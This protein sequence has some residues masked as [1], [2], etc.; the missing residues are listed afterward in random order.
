MNTRSIGAV[1]IGLA[2]LALQSQFTGAEENAQPAGDSV[3]AQEPAAG[4]MQD[5]VAPE[6]KSDA[7]ETSGVTGTEAAGVTEA[8]VV[9]AQPTGG[10]APAA[11]TDR[12]QTRESDALAAVDTDPAATDELAETERRYRDAVEAI[13]AGGGAYDP[14]LSQQLLGLGLSYQQAGRHLEA[15]E[16]LSRAAHITRVNEGLFSASGIPIIEQLIESHAALGE[17]EE[18]GNRYHQMF[19]IHNRAFG[20]GDVRILPA[21]EKLS[22]WHMNAYM[23]ELGSDPLN[24]LMTARNLYD[25]AA[26][27]IQTSYGLADPRLANVLRRRALV[28]YYLAAYTPAAETIE[29]GTGG[30]EIPGG[31]NYAVNSYTSGRQA[32]ATVVEI[33]QQNPDSSP[34][35]KASALAELGDWHLLFR[36]RQ[37]AMGIYR[38]AWN[39]AYGNEGTEQSTSDAIFDRPRALPIVPAEFDAAAIDPTERSATGYVLI[40]FDVT[41]RGEA[42][43][44]EIIEAEPA[45]ADARIK[46]L[47][48]RLQDTPFRPRFE[49][50]EPVATPG[51]KYRYVYAL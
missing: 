38:E 37:S 4:S 13:E 24:H 1:I 5:S 30:G 23:E 20:S 10:A 25:S 35:D 16:T 49:N 41:E 22:S 17:W 43:A 3:P 44:I 18:V 48:K 46:R 8:A 21:L 11:D 12:R 2:C 39:L 32:L 27:I 6:E 14:R 36:R 45:N 7:A 34:I 26:S 29:F 28:D 42:D 9:E 47:R 31:V 33:Y 19:R 40:S 51:V 15:V 50:G